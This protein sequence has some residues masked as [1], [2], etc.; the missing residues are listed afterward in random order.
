MRA[1]PALAIG[2]AIALPALAAPVDLL[3]NTK[4]RPVIVYADAPA[5]VWRALQPEGPYA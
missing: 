3:K 2:A 4:G 5:S 1:G